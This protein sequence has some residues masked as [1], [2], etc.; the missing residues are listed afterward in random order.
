MM[1][2]TVKEVMD[3]VD[4]KL[5]KMEA[6]REIRCP[7]CKYLYDWEDVGHHASFHGENGPQRADCPNCEHPFMVEECVEHVGDVTPHSW[8]RLNQSMGKALRLAIYAGM[9]FHV[10][11][12]GKIMADF[13]GGRWGCY[14]SDAWE[15]KFRLACEENNRS[16]AISFEAWKGR[17][18]FTIEEPHTDTPTRIYVGRRFEW[19]GATV[20]CTSFGGDGSYITAVEYRTDTKQYE[21]KVKRRSRITIADIREVRRK[22]KQYKTLVDRFNKEVNSDTGKRFV[23]RFRKATGIK[24]DKQ[25]DAVAAGERVTILEAFFAEEDED[26]AA[27]AGGGGADTVSA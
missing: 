14:G 26:T 12:F 3:A 9:E 15:S 16:A 18:P 8:E 6:A 20:I 21:H 22:Q 1:V 17:K 4:R 24:T 27:T 11:D 23:S 13:R 5:A 25:W 7:K 10:T 2:R 19:N